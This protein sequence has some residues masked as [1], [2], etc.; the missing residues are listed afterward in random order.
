VT[1]QEKTVATN[2]TR[3]DFMRR[4]AGTAGAL[5]LGA[6]G[7]WAV[8]VPDSESQEWAFPL[9]GD[10]HIDHLDH[11]DAEWV[12]REKPNDWSQIRNY[13]RITREVTPKLLEV[14]R[15]QATESN[16]PVPFVLQLGDLIEG[17]CGSEALASRQA[18]DA[19]AMVSRAE[20][21][22]PFLFTKGNHDITGPGAAQVYDKVLVPFMAGQAGTGIDGAAFTR[23][24]AGTLLVFYDAYD[25]HSLDWFAGLMAQQSPRRL[26][27]VIHPPVVPY[28]ARSTWHVYS[29]ARQASERERLLELLGAARAVVLCGHLHKYSFLIRRTAHGRFTQLALSSV[30]STADA[31]PRDLIEGVEGY[32]PDLVKLEPNHS[33]DTLDLRRKTLELE[34]PFIEQFEYADTWG[35]ALVSVRGDQVRA[36]VFNGLERQAWKNLDLTSALG[37]V[38]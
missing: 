10:L 4:A 37:E 27:F 32:T 7:S 11:H 36:S 12:T 2:I 29:S 6:G 8:A 9:L 23:D 22:A 17:L 19:L 38:S 26:L 30:A 5:F 28:N 21:R 13:S 1:A 31:Q 20:L 35:H 18:N 25:R 3:R 24:R 14:I 33:P 16:A 15:Q 34:Q